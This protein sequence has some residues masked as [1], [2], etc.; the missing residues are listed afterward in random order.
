MS[1]SDVT[2]ARLSAYLDDALNEV[3]SAQI[4]REL[5]ESEQLRQELARLR[6]EHDRGEHTLGAIWR[7]ERL[8]C[9]TREQ[10]SGYLLETLD[11]QW[12]S[13]IDFHLHTIE[14]PYCLANLADLKQRQAEGTA[15]A[16][17]PRQRR[18]FESSVGL[19]RCQQNPS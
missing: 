16:A 1:S 7:R 4:E 6:E 2:R 15:S 18:M 13:Y 17:A 3:E 8:S 11:P 9:L 5:R 14:C 12:Q 10:L 19:L